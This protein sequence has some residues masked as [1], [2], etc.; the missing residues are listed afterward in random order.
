MWLFTRR[1]DIFWFRLLEDIIE[2]KLKWKRVI[3]KLFFFSFSELFYI[4]LTKIKLIVCAK[5]LI[6]LGF[7]LRILIFWYV[8][9]LFVFLKQCVS[10]FVIKSKKA[11]INGSKWLVLDMYQRRLKHWLVLLVYRSHFVKYNVR[12][13]YV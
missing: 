7:F 8:Q 12:L 10:F 11:F 2:L 5:H 3:D 13:W 1:N 9:S 6:S 4:N